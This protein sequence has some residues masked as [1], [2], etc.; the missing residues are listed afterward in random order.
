MCRTQAKPK[1]VRPSLRN[2]VVLYYT[3]LSMTLWSTLKSKQALLL[4]LNSISLDNILS[5][6]VIVS[7][8]SSSGR[9]CKLVALQLST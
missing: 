4:T 1:I 7:I 5:N 6:M 2:A 8:S 3:L 9:C